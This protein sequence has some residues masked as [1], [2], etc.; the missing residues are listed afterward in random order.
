MRVAAKESCVVVTLTGDVQ[1]SLAQKL[2]LFDPEKHGG[3]A[4]PVAPIGKEVL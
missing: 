4:M 3:E 2:A 1:L